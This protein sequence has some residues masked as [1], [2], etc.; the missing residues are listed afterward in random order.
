MF[1]FRLLG[2]EILQISLDARF[3][4]FVGKYHTL[5]KFVLVLQFSIEILKSGSRRFLA[6]VRSMYVFKTSEKRLS[7]VTTAAW[8]VTLLGP[9]VLIVGLSGHI[10]T[11]LGRSLFFN[12]N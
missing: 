6:T 2:L 11:L 12:R 3:G 8:S 5:F 9:F 1:L 10:R 4:P 7:S